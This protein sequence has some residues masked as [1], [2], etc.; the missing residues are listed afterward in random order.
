MDRYTE[1]IYRLLISS[2]SEILKEFSSGIVLAVLFLLFD[3]LVLR[4]WASLLAIPLVV[5]FVTYVIICRLDVT[6]ADRSL[7]TVETA[8]QKEEAIFDYFDSTKEQTAMFT[9]N[10]RVEEIFK[11]GSSDAMIDT[12]A[13]R[14]LQKLNEI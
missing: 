2:P 8:E 4:T 5:A 10:D 6:Y 13:S 1:R 11:T 7:P 12:L 9:F 14:H 3:L